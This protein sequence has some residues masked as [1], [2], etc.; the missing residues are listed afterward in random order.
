MHSSAMRIN[1]YTAKFMLSCCNCSVDS[2]LLAL[3]RVE[4]FSFDLR[5]SSLKKANNI[6]NRHSCTL[7]FQLPATPSHFWELTL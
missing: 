2:G 5:L 4:I 7:Y 6:D 3:K 1:S